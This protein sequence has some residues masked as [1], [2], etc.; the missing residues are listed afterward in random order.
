[1]KNKNNSQTIKL[2]NENRAG[3]PRGE[4]LWMQLAGREL[5]GG[6]GSVLAIEEVTP[7]PEPVEGAA[8]L[9]ELAGTLRRFIILPK[10]AAETLALWTLH[11]YAFR[12]RDV[13]TY[14]GIE[15]P[16]KRCG[17]TT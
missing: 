2:N 9:D 11:T 4:S 12:L 13:S 6:G 10:W 8:L 5:V 14:I 1:M 15:S 16:E 17:K 7:W 3:D